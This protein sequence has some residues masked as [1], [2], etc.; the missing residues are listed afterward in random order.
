MLWKGF[1]RH[2]VPRTR[3]KKPVRT[4]Y[5]YK[6][7][8]GTQARPSRIAA[9]R[10]RKR[11]SRWPMFLFLLLLLLLFFGCWMES[12]G[13]CGSWTG[14]SGNMFIPCPSDWITKD[15]HGSRLG[16]DFM[17]MVTWTRNICMNQ[18][19]IHIYYTR[20][21]KWNC[22]LRRIFIIS[23]NMY[24]KGQLIRYPWLSCL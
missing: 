1:K 2:R 9:M 22:W 13:E 5:K 15:S 14:W 23:N 8:P 7:F 4:Q 17:D 18:R 12:I 6:E 16:D 11:T 19:Q 21:A 20:K 24:S 10:K 3:K